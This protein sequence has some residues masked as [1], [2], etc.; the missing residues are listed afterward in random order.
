MP[1]DGRKIMSDLKNVLT[2]W[3]IIAFQF[4][5]LTGPGYGCTINNSYGT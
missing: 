3:S 2:S 4:G 1:D 5:A